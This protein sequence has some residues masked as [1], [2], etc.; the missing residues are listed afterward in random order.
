M[1]LSHQQQP[2]K[3]QQKEE[4]EEEK[5]AEEG[6][7]EGGGGKKKEE[8]KEKEKG[9]KGNRGCARRRVGCSWRGRQAEGISFLSLCKAPSL[10]IVVNTLTTQC[11]TLHQAGFRLPYV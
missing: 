6:G 7:R 11:A 2:T 9:R 4:E 5:E 10:I 1:T 3:Q 8:R